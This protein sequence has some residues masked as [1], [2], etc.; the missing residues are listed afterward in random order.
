MKTMGANFRAAYDFRSIRVG[1]TQLV[2]WLLK[3]VT[4][5]DQKCIWWLILFDKS[6]IQT[7]GGERYFDAAARLSGTKKTADV[8]VSVDG[9]WQRSGV[10]TVISIDNGKILDVAIFSKS[11]KGCTSTKKFPHPTPYEAWKLSHNCILILPALPLDWTQQ[12]EL[13]RSLVHQK[14]C[15]DYITPFFMEME[16]ARHIMLSKI[17]MVQLNLLRSLNVSFKKFKRT[18]RKTETH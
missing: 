15:M 12:E 17:Y 2:V 11:Y 13:L 1:R 6:C 4:T 18:G 3:D 5:N 16:T 9:M 8:R 7:S 10:V 14:R